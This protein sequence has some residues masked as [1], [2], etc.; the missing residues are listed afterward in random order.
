M[1]GVCRWPYPGKVFHIDVAPF[2]HLAGHWL[3]A[4]LLCPHKDEAFGAEFG[5]GYACKGPLHACFISICGIPAWI[6]QHSL[7]TQIACVM[8]LPDC[9][10]DEAL[11]ARMHG[12]YALPQVLEQELIL[13]M[14]D[15]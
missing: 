8:L 14:V 15:C 3:D 4:M 2:V 11:C 5:E 7:H 13:L 9:I 12:A 1:S 10:T 6:Y